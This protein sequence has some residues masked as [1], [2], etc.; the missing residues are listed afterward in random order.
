MKEIKQNPNIDDDALKKSN[1]TID[2]LKM[3]CR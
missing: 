2:N 1:L 3:Y